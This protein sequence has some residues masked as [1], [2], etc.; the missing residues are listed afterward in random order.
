MRVAVDIG[1][2]YVKAVSEYGR[3]VVFPSVVA[4]DPGRLLFGLAG[5][6]LDEVGYVVR[7]KETGSDRIVDCAVGEAGLACGNAVRAWEMDDQIF[8]ENSRVLLCTAVALL[9]LPGTV[10][11]LAVGLP[12]K[13]YA[14]LN[15]ERRERL[16][17]LGAYVDVQGADPRQVVFEPPVRVF[18]QAGGAYLHALL[19]EHGLVRNAALLRASVGVIDVGYRTTDLLLLSRTGGRTAVVRADRTGTVDCGVGG[20]YEH[21]WRSLEA[22]LGRPV[23][24]LRVEKAFV[25]NKGI[26]TYRGWEIDLSPRAEEG[27]RLLAR[28]IGAAVKR[29]WGEDLDFAER[30]LV[31]GGG[32]QDLFPYLREYVPGAVCGE[33]SLFANA[34]GYLYGW[35]FETKSRT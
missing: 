10:C 24:L 22:E 32:G 12:L 3:R 2:G 33:D 28:E 7:Y 29:L 31:T 15:A 4:V 26:L 14:G 1:Y 11:R 25:W 9:T 19:N 35:A 6:A 17:R 8:H 23:D 13:V 16:N 27:R 18:P 20:V 30:V 34:L 5:G 21:V